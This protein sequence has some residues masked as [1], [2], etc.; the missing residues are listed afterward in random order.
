MIGYFSTLAKRLTTQDHCSS[1]PLNRCGHSERNGGREKMGISYPSLTTP[2]INW[3]S[4]TRFHSNT[5]WLSQPL[6]GIICSSIWG[7]RWSRLRIGPS[8][9]LLTGG[10]PLLPPS[11]GP[12]PRPPGPK[13]G[14]CRRRNDLLSFHP[15]DTAAD[16]VAEKTQV[17]FRS[18]VCYQLFAPVVTAATLE[19]LYSPILWALV[20]MEWLKLSNK[21]EARMVIEQGTCLF[22][23]THE[24]RCDMYFIASL[25]QYEVTCNM[26]LVA[27][28]IGVN[29]LLIDCACSCATHTVW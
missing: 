14:I 7:P 19:K 23:P 18:Y 28:S 3:S 10:C 27:V 12:P 29:G 11:R 8:E 2:R 20:A 5:K 1:P 17:A 21:L 9:A 26:S 16:V 4:V 6:G 24:C 25:W 15:T 22:W 13:P